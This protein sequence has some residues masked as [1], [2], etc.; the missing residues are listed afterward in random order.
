MSG[1]G[2]N[3]APPGY[4][5]NLLPLVPTWNYWP[6]GALP[7]KNSLKV[8]FKLAA[9]TGMPINVMLTRVW[10]GPRVRQ[11]IQQVLLQVT[12]KIFPQPIRGCGTWARGFSPDLAKNK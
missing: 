5:A 9:N 1:C 2:G 3:N 11:N 4:T 6:L 7:E 10:G 12:N 8:F